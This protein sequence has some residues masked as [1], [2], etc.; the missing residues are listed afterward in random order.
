MRRGLT[1]INLL[2]AIGS[3]ALVLAV[4][5]PLWLQFREA[6]R[7]AVCALRL[8]NLATSLHQYY[9]NFQHL[10]PSA[11]YAG[12]VH[13][14]DMRV[15]LKS[16]IPG[17]GGKGVART[18]YSFHVLLLPYQGNQGL[19]FTHWD[20][21]RD[22]AFDGPNLLN[23]A[24]R[25]S[26]LVCPSYGGS[27]VSNAPDYVNSAAGKPAI[28]NYKALGATTLACLQDSASVTRDDLNGGVLHPYACYKFESLSAITATAVLVET[29]EE[30]YAAWWDGATASIP[31]FHPGVGNVADDRAPT[32][33]LGTLAL[34]LDSHG[35]QQS[36][37]LAG[38]FGG[39][40]DMQWGASS[41][42][43][44][45]VLHAYLGTE[46]RALTKDVDPVVY[47]AN[48]SRRRS[49]DGEIQRCYGKRPKE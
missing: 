7:R 19:N 28:T 12:D 30:K 2:V 14:A 16:V 42:H 17:Q 34:N 44:G 38:Q 26:F 40:E 6:Q 35:G 22:E 43:P 15:S 29:K 18:P 20:I 11:S 36:F 21:Q 8:K 1:I 24:K 47:S 13:R 25:V 10:P 31:G 46:V 48:I 23:A 37:I 49:D 3:I 39:R 45:L 41:D 9:D 33:P 5:V 27:G 4:A 32:P